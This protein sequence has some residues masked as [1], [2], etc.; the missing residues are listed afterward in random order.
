MSHVQTYIYSK[1]VFRTLKYL[2]YYILDTG[3]KDKLKT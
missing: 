1:D 3:D 2:V